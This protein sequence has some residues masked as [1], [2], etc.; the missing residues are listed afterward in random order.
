MVNEDRREST[1][2]SETFRP[3]RFAQWISAPFEK[4]AAS[5]R[6]TSTVPI[7]C[8]SAFFEERVLHPLDR[9]PNKPAVDA[10][11]AFIR[12]SAPPLMV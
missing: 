5:Y 2:L 1:R 12:A 3:D 11:A 10:I 9:E 7:E 4:E 8:T 6:R